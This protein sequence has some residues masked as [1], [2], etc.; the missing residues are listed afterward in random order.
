MRNVY[1]TGQKTCGIWEAL[2]GKGLV[3]RNAL[4][5]AESSRDEVIHLEEEEVEAYERERKEY[6]TL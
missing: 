2:A 6:Y 1:H 4:G 5:D 3:D